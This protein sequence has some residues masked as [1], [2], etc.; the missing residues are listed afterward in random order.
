M[1]SL[2]NLSNHLSVTPLGGGTHRHRRSAAIS[3]DFDA[4]GLGL[5]SPSPSSNEPDFQKHY[6]FNNCEDFTNKPSS[7][8]FS[9]P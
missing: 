6:N 1:S 2:P 5:F 3:G 7:S 8:E 9:F 4:M